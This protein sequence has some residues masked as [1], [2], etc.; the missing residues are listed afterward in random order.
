[1]KKV[2]SSLAV[3]AF[4]INSNAQLNPLITSWAINTASATGYNSL[5]SN[6]QTV[7]YSAS[8]VYVS[9]SCIP[10]YNIGPWASN[11]NTPTNQNFVCKFTLAPT[12]NTSTA[13][14]TALGNMGLWSNGV[15]IFNPKDGQYWSGSAFTMGATTNG[16]NRNALV[17]EGVSFDA[18]LGH[19]APNGAYHNHVNPSCLYNS[20][21][22]TVHSPIIGYAFDGYPVYGAYAYT[23]TNGTGPI[24]RMTPSF[25]L[26]AS[27]GSV[28]LGANTASAAASAT[29][30]TTRNAGPPVNSTYPLGNM[31]EDYIYAAGSGDLDFH[32]GRFCVTPEYP[33][34][35][36]A[37]FVTIDMTGY[38]VYPFVIGPTYYGVVQA[39]NTG[40]TGSHVAIS[41]ATTVYTP[42]PTCIGELQNLPIKY[43]VMPN[44]TQ[45]YLFIYMDV[46]SKNNVKGS[47]IDAKGKTV[48]KIDYLQPSIA[49]SL[50]MT[51]LSSGVYFLIL[52]SDNQKTTQKII[53]SN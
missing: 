9:A 5:P 29:T 28:L 48:K 15:A 12:Q 45:D 2:I 18:C 53:K 6:V 17:Y 49:Y 50:D 14:Y 52:E 16:F 47:L 35:T 13:V 20:T 23:N 4:A 40:P 10:G 37:Y 19:P 41:E 36:Y 27:T 32:N 1:M 24:K 39:G 42:A 43:K 26:A 34:G 11:P 22:T 44:P 51:D 46:E 25:V 21:L 31:L 33:A 38:P 30:A 8:Q 3:F 7:Q